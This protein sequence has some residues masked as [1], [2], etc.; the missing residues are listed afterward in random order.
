VLA[1]SLSIDMAGAE[2]LRNRHRPEKVNGQLAPAT[3]SMMPR[4]ALK[5]MEDDW[6]EHL[7]LVIL[8]TAY[9]QSRDATTD[10]EV[11]QWSIKNGQL[12]SSSRPSAVDH[13][14]IDL[15]FQ[16]WTQAWGRLLIL[17]KRFYRK[18][19]L[20][21]WKNHF[22]FIFNHIDR[23]KYWQVMLRYDIDIRQ[24][25][26]QGP[27]DP[28]VFQE[29]IYQHFLREDRLRPVTAPQHSFPAPVHTAHVHLPAASSSNGPPP[30]SNDHASS[31]SRAQQPSSGHAK[32]K[33]E[34]KAMRCF[35]CG[36]HDG[37]GPSA[38]THISR[39]NGRPILISKPAGSSNWEIDGAGFCFKFNT[40]SGCTAPNCKYAPHI[41]SLC[42]SSAH[43][44]QTCSN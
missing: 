40:T 20:R 22:N 1:L 33:R 18:R 8:T 25:A 36:G 43:G 29:N 10:P 5:I 41:C 38:C 2:S 35:R 14:E 37:H 6:Q 17:I 30:Y 21:R 4:K 39:P 34:K 28:G 7:S 19:Y 3:S 42:R 26:T 15:M 32:P 44:A 9:T 23:D 16:E 24:R 11:A 13:R 27:I 31:S 12:V